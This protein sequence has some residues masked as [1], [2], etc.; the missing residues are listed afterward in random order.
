[1]DLATTVG[2]FMNACMAAVI[3]TGMFLFICLN[4]RYK[5]EK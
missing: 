3:V 2:T 1:M 5:D 4:V